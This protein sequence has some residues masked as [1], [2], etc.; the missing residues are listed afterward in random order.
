M[1]FTDAD[2]AI[3]TW[4]GVDRYQQTGFDPTK[5]YQPSPVST[6]PPEGITSFTHGNGAIMTWD[7]RAGG[8]VQ[9]GYDPTKDL[10]KQP[11][12]P[13]TY[14]QVGQDPYGG[15]G[16]WNPYQGRWEPPA[17]YISPYE[18]QQLGL[19]QQQLGLGQQRL[20]SEQQQWQQSLSWQQ[21]A[22]QMQL[23][24]ERRKRIAELAAN[25]RSWLEYASYTGGVPT[26]QPWMLPL[27][28]Q[29][30]GLKAGEP[31]PGYSPQGMAGMPEMTTPSTQLWARMGPTAQQQLYGYQTART[32][33]MPEEQTWRLWSQ[34]PPSGQFGGLQQQR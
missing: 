7:G 26:I 6:P 16:W 30:Y 33:Q 22:S 10:S 20:A 11:Q 19:G 14:P 4:D 3:R 15:Q 27:M 32:G 31:I 28:P 23:E 25:P 2:G 13:I 17:G 21:Q 1:S 5:I 24:E 34:A 8:Y 29:Q 18:Q 12:P 9:T